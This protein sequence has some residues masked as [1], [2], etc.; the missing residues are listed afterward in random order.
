MGFCS[1]QGIFHTGLYNFPS[2]NSI[3]LSIKYK[4]VLTKIWCSF[5]ASCSLVLKGQR[6]GGGHTSTFAQRDRLNDKNQWRGADVWNMTAGGGPCCTFLVTL[7]INQKQTLPTQST[8]VLGCIQTYKYAQLHTATSCNV[9][10]PISM[11]LRETKAQFVCSDLKDQQH[12]WP[13]DPA[14][15]TFSTIRKEDLNHIR[16]NQQ[17]SLNQAIIWRQAWTCE[18]TR[19]QTGIWHPYLSLLKVGMKQ[20]TTTLSSLH[21]KRAS[22]VPSDQR[23]GAPA[24][25]K[26]LYLFLLL[27]GVAAALQPEQIKFSGCQQLKKEKDPAGDPWSHPSRTHQCITLKPVCVY[28]H[29][30]GAGGRDNTQ[31]TCDVWH[32]HH[33]C[34]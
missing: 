30:D 15:G 1:Q 3:V 12:M 7:L 17:N 8:C 29:P 13:F 4:N 25:S 6:W 34:Y 14:H 32:Q 16:V 26:H 28:P 9:L 33:G 20:T 21:L 18:V 24:Q 5:S 2:M 23:D 11:H 31:N 10:P 27:T 19:E 22:V